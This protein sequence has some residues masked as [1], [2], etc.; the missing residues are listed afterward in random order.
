MIHAKTNSAT[1]LKDLILEDIN[2]KDV[3]LYFCGELISL[4]LQEEF[5]K[6][7]I[8]L[9]KI[10][11]YRIKPL[12]NFSHSFIKEVEDH[13]FDF[14]LLYS[15]NSAK[16]FLD[17][18][19]QSNFFELLSNSKI[20]CLS[21]NILDFVQKSGFKNSSTFAQIEILKKFYE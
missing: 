9:E 20:L 12:K 4:D 14:I 2:P 8:K 1:G 16:I 13:H 11:S 3:L 19:A 17:L 21:Q 7:D 10:I 18:I 5:A 15:K 6:Y